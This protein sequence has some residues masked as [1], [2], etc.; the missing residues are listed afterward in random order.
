MESNE[1]NAVLKMGCA[2]QMMKNRM[3]QL[4]TVPPANP[5]EEEDL[6]CAWIYLRLLL[7]RIDSEKECRSWE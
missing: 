2:G 1:E 5:H 4:K 6:K 7:D 3:V